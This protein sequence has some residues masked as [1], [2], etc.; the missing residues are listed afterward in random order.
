MGELV[1][2]VDEQDQVL[3]AVDRGEAIRHRWLHRI[4]TTVCRDR[5]GRVLVHRR[6]ENVSRFPGQYNWLIGGAAEVGE[7]Y[8]DAAARE[9]TEE[10]G[11]HTSARLVLKY[12]CQGAISP[13]WLGL[14]EATVTEEVTPDTS[15]IAW[16]EWLPE[17]ELASLIRHRAF[18]P[19]GREAFERYRARACR[20]TR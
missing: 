12:L 5:D 13:Y 4:A 15:E 19:D 8:E 2:R 1:E 9:L 10:L 3:G 11:I 18:V 7:S 6:A 14:H 16:H 17:A 20:P